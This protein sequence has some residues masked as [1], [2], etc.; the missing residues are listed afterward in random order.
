MI[1]Y[2]N[3]LKQFKIY[4]ENFN[5][6]D[7]MIAMK[8]SHSY[9]TADLAMKLAKRL[10]LREEEIV[11]AKTLG[12]LHDI[13]RFVQYEKTKTYNDFK[14]KVD[15]AKL[16]TDYLFGEEHIKDF[17][18]PK[19]YYSIL[20]KAI[21]NHNKLKIEDGLKEKELFFAKFI[22]DVDKI[23][24]LRQEGVT[25]FGS[26]GHFNSKV[27]DKVKKEFY[28]HHLID[29]K[30]IQNI[31]DTI[32]TEIAYVFDINFKESYEL[33]NETDNLE[34][35]LT[36]K[37]VSKECEEEYEEIKKEIRKYLEERICD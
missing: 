22:R 13:G 17:A 21:Y 27:T 33:L 4:L 37:E 14:A 2:E 28:E 32:L 12:L 6:K 1:N 10:E 19:K 30:E 9:H 25:P 3:V 5:T 15:H 16:A 35:Y 34:L 31:S 18:I 7:E 20:E 23:D 11:L 29:S 36:S 8:I 26:S 24:I